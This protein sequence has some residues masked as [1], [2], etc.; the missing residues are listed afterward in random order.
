M[1]QIF[2]LAGLRID[3]GICA[4]YFSVFFIALI[5][6]TID[7][8][9]GGGGLLILPVLLLLGL[10]PTTAM[11][12]NKVRA[13]AG[14]FS[15]MLHFLDKKTIKFTRCMLQYFIVAFCGSVVGGV[16]LM[17]IDPTILTKIIPR[18]SH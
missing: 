16:V 2:A 4:S 17:A 5:A 11:A 3:D 14:D 10:P 18:T 7:A 13:T 15:A 9:A 8:V 6:S 1:N 12:T